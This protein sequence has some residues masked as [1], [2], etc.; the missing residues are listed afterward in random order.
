MIFNLPTNLHKIH[1]TTKM[2][3]VSIWHEI[4]RSEISDSLLESMHGI[5]NVIVAYRKAMAEY[6]D[7][8]TNSAIKNEEDMIKAML[9]EI[10]KV[11]VSYNTTLL[12]L[13]KSDMSALVKDMIISH[14]AYQNMQLIKSLKA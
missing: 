13:E 3:M 7:M 2:F 11:E 12:I 14:I 6:H 10:K 1:E 5:D 8:R 9:R 4:C